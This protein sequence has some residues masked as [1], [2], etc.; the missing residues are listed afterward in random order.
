M[1]NKKG[2]ELSVYFMAELLV[3]ALISYVVM[4]NVFGLVE[5][6]AVLREVVH[7]D[8]RMMIDTLAALPG[9]AIVKYP[10]DLSAF[11]IVV[12]DNSQITLFKEGDTAKNWK[13]FFLP[14]GYNISERVEKKANVC[15]VKTK[16]TIILKECL[17]E[18][19][20][21]EGK[22]EDGKIKESEWG[23]DEII[24]REDVPDCNYLLERTLPDY[25]QEGNDMRRW[26][27]TESQLKNLGLD[28]AYSSKSRDINKVVLHYTY[29][30]GSGKTV[31]EDWVN[32]EAQ[33]SAHYI[34]DREGEITSVID[35][36]D[37]A[38]H[39]VNNNQRSI[40]IELVNLGPGCDE[41]FNGGDGSG[42][43]N[44]FQ[45]CRGVKG[46]SGIYP[47]K[48]GYDISL[49]YQSFTIKQ[50]ES[51]ITLA[52]GLKEKYSLPSYFGSSGVVGGFTGHIYTED[53][54]LGQEQKRKVDP[55]PA[56]PWEYFGCRV[57][58]EENCESRFTE[59]YEKIDREEV[60][61]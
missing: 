34:I 15:L 59:D 5:K 33:V 2:V 44:K 28:Y 22:D 29:G 4:H 47:N 24:I 61:S 50:M 54:V 49:E 38:Y 36:N 10:H 13:H 11:I 42:N 14:Q 40:G 3:L 37:I 48:P 9:D 30:V 31:A 51:L 32:R 20:K 17:E 21:L 45:F 6:D 35:E 26:F 1:M 12:A 46:I 39:A 56:F 16:K 52:I 27:C 57:R 60:I 41:E 18:M 19:K 55:G 7:E 25:V 23:E 43:Y 53:I 58:E 8:L